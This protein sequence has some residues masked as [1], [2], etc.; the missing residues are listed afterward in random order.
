[1]TV[2]F[3]CIYDDERYFGLGVPEAGAPLRLYPLAGDTLA[4]LLTTAASTTGRT[5]PT[6]SPGAGRPSTYRPRTVTGRGRCRR[7]C[8]HT[9]GTRWSAAS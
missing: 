4:A 9:W 7:C 2:V 1:M 8:P 5:P 3:E 6:C